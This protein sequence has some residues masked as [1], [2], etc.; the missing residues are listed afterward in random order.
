MCSSC[1]NA[2]VVNG[3]STFKEHAVE[4]ERGLKR[5][6]KDTL[7]M[8]EMI[9]C[10]R[11]KGDT[12]QRALDRSL[13]YQYYLMCWNQ[14]MVIP[15][16]NLKDK[17]KN[18][19]KPAIYSFKQMRREMISKDFRLSSFFDSIYNAS[20]PKDRSNKDLDKLDKK[21]AVECYIICGNQNSKL[22][23]F[24]KDVSLFVDLMGVSTEAIDALSCASITI[25]RRHLDRD[26]TAIADNHPHREEY[27]MK[28]TILLDFFEL[29][30]KEMDSYI[31]ALQELSKIAKIVSARKDII[32]F[33]DAF[34]VQKKS[35]YTDEDNLT[36]LTKKA[37]VFLLEIFGNVYQRLGQSSIVEGWREKITYKLASLSLVIDKK[38][39]LLGFSSEHLP[40]YNK[41]DHCHGL[42]RSGTGKS[43]MV[44]ACGHGYHE[45]CFTILNGKCC[46]CES[47]LKLDK[48]KSNL[49]EIVEAD[50]DSPQDQRVENEDDILEVLR[51]DKQAFSRVEQAYPTALEKFLNTN[52]ANI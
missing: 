4:W 12:E 13:A 6:R 20:L 52:I 43:S 32:A 21:L 34:V 27:K 29:S 41:C 28:D 31:N 9:A 26:R 15:F 35:T 7:S 25:S 10:L 3:T 40:S 5:Q 39:M 23:A 17:E 42:L 38:Q 45:S 16:W 46:Y 11:R 36:L 18:K 50:E 30:L 49:E 44:I 48:S 22:T 47:I 19:E 37:Q 8:S 51:K 33:E 14:S 2:I 24:K 1:Y